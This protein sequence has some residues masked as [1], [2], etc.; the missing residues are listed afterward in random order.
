MS[1]CSASIIIVSRSIIAAVMTWLQV[2]T[3]LGARNDW[4]SYGLVN[5]T[6][7]TRGA[8]SFARDMHDDIVAL[9]PIAHQ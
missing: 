5:N 3:A 8:K 1:T 9:L 2:L 4:P 7:H 6:W